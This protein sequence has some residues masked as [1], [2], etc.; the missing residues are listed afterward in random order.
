MFQYLACRSYIH[1]NRALSGLLQQD[2][3]ETAKGYLEE[4]LPNKLAYY[5][6]LQKAHAA[7]YLYLNSDEEKAISKI[8]LLQ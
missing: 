1:G 6:Y 3:M 2:A 4:G 5:D 7:T 8:F